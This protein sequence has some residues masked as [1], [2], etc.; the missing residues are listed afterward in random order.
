MLLPVWS[1]NEIEKKMVLFFSAQHLEGRC[2]F[3]IPLDCILKPAPAETAW[4]INT[5]A[6]AATATEGRSL[7]VPN[8]LHVLLQPASLV[9]RNS[10]FLAGGALG[11]VLGSPQH[12]PEQGQERRLI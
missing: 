6:G 3:L 1:W 12:C 5:E 2:S 11:A 10:R 9:H 4:Q 7:W 8:L